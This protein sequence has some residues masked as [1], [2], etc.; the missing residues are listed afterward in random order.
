MPA[1]DRAILSTLQPDHLS[2]LSTLY[3]ATSST[4]QSA[5]AQP[6]PT[7]SSFNTLK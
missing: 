3:Y 7:G 6:I 1:L 2:R 5:A 4:E